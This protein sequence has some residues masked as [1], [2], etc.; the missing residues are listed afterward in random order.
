VKFKYVEYNS[1]KQKIYKHNRQIY[2]F[3]P[4]VMLWN[5]DCYYVLGWS[6]SHGKVIT[7]RVDRIAAPERS[8]ES[9]V[10]VPTDFDPS[11]YVRSVFLMYDGSEQDV[12]IRCENS[13]MKN[14]VDRF[15]E[16]VDTTVLDDGHFSAFIHV[17]ASPTFF[18]WVFGFAGKM[19]ITAPDSVVDEYKALALSVAGKSR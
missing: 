12:L 1:H 15:G 2:S 11:M 7:F 18:G 19:E 13:L 3:S 14:V 9:A 4:Y 5:N 10:P 6:D 16:D 8:E 17:S